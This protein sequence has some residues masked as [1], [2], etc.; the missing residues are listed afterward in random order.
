MHVCAVLM[1]MSVRAV[2]ICGVHVC[3]RNVHVGFSLS[4]VGIFVSFDQ[5][6][7]DVL[8]ALIVGADDTPYQNGSSDTL[9][10]T[11]HSD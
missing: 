4:L 9:I 3:L 8:R 10:H 6:R 11:H 5:T 2:S 7:Y 1:C